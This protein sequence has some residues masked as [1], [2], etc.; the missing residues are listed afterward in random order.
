MPG[1][2]EGEHVLLVDDILDSGDTM[3][4]LLDA[5]GQSR[6]ASLRTCVLLR[7]DRPDLPDRLDADFAG[8]DVPDEFLVGYGLDYD[9][10]YRNLP[11][12]CVLAEH[13]R[14]QIE[15]GRDREETP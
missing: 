4:R 13:A 1:D 15:P 12:I 6:P 11:E 9:N 10:L 5:A 2:L 14:P 8:F 7:K 3:R